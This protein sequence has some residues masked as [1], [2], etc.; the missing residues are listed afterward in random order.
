[1]SDLSKS[2]LYQV[3]RLALE[4]TN[5]TERNDAIMEL[6]RRYAATACVASSLRAY[7]K[8][9]GAFIDGWNASNFATN[10]YRVGSNFTRPLRRAWDSGRQMRLDNTGAK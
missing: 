7:M 1:M 2:K 9:R 5:D 6:G 8:V 4:G 10:P 3:Q